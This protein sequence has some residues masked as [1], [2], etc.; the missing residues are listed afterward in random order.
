MRTRPGPL[1]SELRELAGACHGRTVSIGD[2]LDAA[3]HRGS[4]LIALVF[5]LPFLLPVPLPGLSII[6]GSVIALVGSA[7]ALGERPWLPRLLRKRR[8]PSKTLVKVF[9]GGMRISRKLERWIRPQGKWF[10][11]AWV[12]KR[13]NGAF[14]ALAGGL[15]AL[16][17]PPGTNFPPAS[18]IILLTLGTIEE[19]A[20]FVVA[21]YFAFAVNVA[22]FG[23]LAMVAWDLI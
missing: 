19:N 9:A 12:L 10:A 1:T 6:F 22:L 21:G 4:A 14:I 17:L 20:F 8:L 13:V 5:S 7:I 11:D 18:V 3:S 16:P 2:L 23:G 15:L